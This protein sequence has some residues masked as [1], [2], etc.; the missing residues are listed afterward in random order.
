[1]IQLWDESV[2]KILL[3]LASTQEKKRD[4]PQG[5]LIVKH[6][7]NKNETPGNIL[8]ISQQAEDSVERP[9]YRVVLLCVVSAEDPDGVKGS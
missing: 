9:K 8:F 2:F 3:N 6:N 7:S 4:S 5:S 1:M